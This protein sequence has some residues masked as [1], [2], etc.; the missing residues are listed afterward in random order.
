[1]KNYI[2][3]RIGF[4]AGRIECCGTKTQLIEFAEKFKDERFF[5]QRITE[6]E[7]KEVDTAFK[8]NRVCFFNS[9]AEEDEDRIRIIL[10]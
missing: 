3:V 7:K 1:M 6:E 5:L 8:Y 4:A 9:V 10:G 2:L